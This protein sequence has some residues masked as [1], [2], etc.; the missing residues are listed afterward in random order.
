[1]NNIAN[2]N[3]KKDKII[4]CIGCDKTFSYRS[5]LSHHKTRCNGSN[6]AKL[7]IKELI[8]K[9][10]QLQL[11]IDKANNAS[12]V[13]LLKTI[14]ENTVLKLKIEKLTIDLANPHILNVHQNF[15]NNK[16]KHTCHFCTSTFATSQ[17]LSKHT[18]SCRKKLDLAKQ[19]TDLTYT[20]EKKN[21]ELEKKNE[22]LN[23]KNEEL[24]QDKKTIATLALNNSTNYKNSIS[25]ISYLTRNSTE[26]LFLKELQDMTIL[27]KEF[28]T[29]LDYV[30]NLISKYKIGNLSH[31]LGDF[32]ICEY[33]KEN[34]EYQSIWN[35]NYSRAVFIIKIVVDGECRWVVDPNGDMV[36][37]T[38]IT[39]I[40]K[41]IDT[42]IHKFN[43]VC[44]KKA[45]VSIHVDE[46][47]E[48]TKYHEFS[49]QLRTI[50]SNHTLEK[51]ILKY[52]ASQLHWD[53]NNIN[54]LN[55][56]NTISK[57]TVKLL[58]KSSTVLFKTL[59]KQSDS[60]YDEMFHKHC[61]I[62][63]DEY[64]EYSDFE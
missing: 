55:I 37:N 60:V 22:E 9:N 50:I 30:S 3:N 15:N 47:H 17:G 59:N 41:Y 7:E 36:I 51:D 31:Y 25:D 35:T 11:N 16:I 49:L 1:M 14:E 34:K 29:T 63:D 44:F 45:S 38:I 61:I 27:H 64:V 39:P 26:T 21:K 6:L 46:K 56:I 23:K 18:V 54:T 5:S 13:T 52:I 8:V 2:I 24:Q 20:L 12:T 42:L 32:L 62:D 28:K 48:Y 19:V 10:N 33:K 43:T 4:I 58:N 57:S 40:L 53:K